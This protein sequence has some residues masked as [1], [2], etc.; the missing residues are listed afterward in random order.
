MR[1]GQVKRR[2]VVGVLMG[3]MLS[4][5]PA[6]AALNAYLTIQGSKQG[7]FKGESATEK[8][9]VTSVTHSATMASDRATGMMTGRRQHGLITITKAIDKASPMFFQAQAE[10]EVLSQV[11]IVFENSG[12]GAGKEKIAQTIEL[13]DATIAGIKK[14]GNMEEITIDYQT[15]MVTYMNGNKSATDAWDAK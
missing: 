7:K 5:V 10:H 4:A 11:T 9:P 13:K 15:I 2:V 14:T 6:M 3:A 12:A 8:I 1:I